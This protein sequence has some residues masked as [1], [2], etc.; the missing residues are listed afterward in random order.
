[1]GTQPYNPVDARASVNIGHGYKRPLIATVMLVGLLGLFFM[2]GFWQ[3]GRAAEKRA[4]LES[5][6]AADAAARLTALVPDEAAEALR[7]RTFELQGAYLP[8]RQILLDNMTDG[9]SNGYQVLTPFRSGDRVVLVN[10][11]WVPADGD[12]ELLPWVEV[13][14]APRTIVARLNSYPSPGLRLEQ[15]AIASNDWPRRLLFPDREQLAAALGMSLPDYQL[16]LDPAEP[17]GYLRKWQATS[18]GPQKHMGYAVQWFSFAA[19][20]C[21]FYLILM[22]QW[23]R[24]RRQL[25]DAATTMPSEAET[26]P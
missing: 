15:P 26:Q 11:G 21:L 17:D 23:I 13:D 10:R 1:M 3:L 8:E 16:L 24:A 4:V 5:F 6:D 7:F 19:L 9:G 2:A 12:R 20:A 25:R 22:L 14:A 18:S